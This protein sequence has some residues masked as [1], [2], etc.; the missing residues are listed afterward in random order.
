MMAK[1]IVI[2]H[3]HDLTLEDVIAVAGG[4]TVQLK[5]ATKRMLDRNRKDVV[6]YIEE[7]SQPA[8][9]FN[10]GFGSNV[11]EKVMPESLR[12][13]QENLIRSH[14]CGVGDP[15]PVEVV[16]ATMFLRAASL[17]R[18]YSGVR[19]VIITALIDCLNKGVI[20]VVPSLGS[21]SAS[22][23]LAPLSHVALCLM[24]EGDAFL[25]DHKTGSFQ[26]MKAAKALRARKLKPIRL[27]MKEGLALNNGVQFSTALIALATDGMMCLIKTAAAATALSAQVMLGADTPFREDLHKLRRHEGSQAMA[28]CIFKLMEGSRIRDFHRDY[29]IDGEIQDPYNLRCAA[30]ILGPCI[31]L[32]WRAKKTIEIETNSVTDNPIILRAGR[33][34]MIENKEKYMD[35]VV[36]IVS[37][38]HFHGM[39]IAVDGYGLLQAGAIMARLSNLRCVRYVDG[40]KNKGLGSHLKWPGTVPPSEISGVP[41]AE[42]RKIEKRKAT[43]SAMMIPEYTSAGLTNWLWGQAMP[44]HLLSLSTDS[45]QEDHVSMAVNVA[46]RAYESLPRVAEV[47]AIELAYAGQAAAIR[48]QMK[49]IPSRAAKG[50]RTHPKAIKDWYPVEKGQ[51]QL[52]KACQQVLSVVRKYFPPVQKDRYMAEEITA[53]GEAILRGEVVDA[54]AGEGDFFR[55]LHS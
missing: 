40:D 38:G 49:A 34:S 30:Q 26:R 4:E 36:E 37:A 32:I 41:E 13:L 7:T 21:V 8:Y 25:V 39:P 51:L 53:L 43:Q 5:E 11:K 50:E 14:A 28:E 24:G 12:D 6:E 19:S 55:N 45:G 35:K 16:R 48:A 20:P 42:R 27:E 22:G 9:G 15:A 3:E 1:Q 54:L 23:D 44:T 17:A 2:D 29:M 33:H 18:G 52:S 31:E 10:R 46:I 47:L